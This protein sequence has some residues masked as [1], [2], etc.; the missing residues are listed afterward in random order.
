MNPSRLARLGAAIAS[1]W[2]LGAQATPVYHLVD[3][4]PNTF[5]FDRERAWRRHR[6]D[7][8]RSRARSGARRR[9]ACPVPERVGGG[10]RRQRRRHR[11]E[12]GRERPVPLVRMAARR[13][14]RRASPRRR[15][16]SAR[17]PAS[18]P[19][20]AR[21]PA[22]PTTPR[23]PPGPL[24]ALGRRRG[25]GTRRR[26]PELQRQRH[27]P[28]RRHRRQHVL[29]R[30]PGLHLE[31]RRHAAAGRGPGRRLQRRPPERPGPPGR[32]RC[33]SPKGKHRTIYHGA[34]WNG[35]KWVDLGTLDGTGESYGYGINDSDDVVGTSESDAG[36]DPRLPLHRRPDARS[37]RPRRQR[38]RLDLRH[39]RRHRRRRQR[40]S[41]RPGSPPTACTTV[42][43]C[44]CPSRP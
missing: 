22:T 41:A 27:Q 21:S 36:L 44:W 43:S 37:R 3:L 12:P 4:G 42:A 17:W 31:Q 14:R 40:S 35:H 9:V 23:R 33:N 10:H 20:T 1:A 11:L 7:R 19:P 2:A 38:R 26:R 34:L 25:R 32:A 24:R 39:P 15:R 16:S 29:S 30:E 8:S 28:P 5:A 6:P 13:R 18:S